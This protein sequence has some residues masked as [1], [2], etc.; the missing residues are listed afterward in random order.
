[1]DHKIS[2]LILLHV[3]NTHYMAITTD[4]IDKCF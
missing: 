4:V 2:G 3:N 1:M